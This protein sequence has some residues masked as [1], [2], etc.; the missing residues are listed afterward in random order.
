MEEQNRS[1]PDIKQIFLRI[2]FLGLGISMPAVDW[3]LFGWFH[4]LLPLFTFF[5]LREQGMYSG[6]RI[7][8]VSTVAGFFICLLLSS[9]SL[10]VFAV[11]LI[12]AGYMLAYSASKNEEPFLSGLKATAVLCLGWAICLSGI[13]LPGEQSPYVQLLA[14]LNEGINEVIKHYKESGNGSIRMDV[15]METTMEQ[16]KVGLPL[17]LPSIIASFAMVIVFFTAITGNRIVAARCTIQSWESFRFWQLPDKFIWLT[18]LTGILVFIP[19]NMLKTIGA[20]LLLLLS[21]TYCFQGFSITVFFMN[22]WKVPIFIRSFIYVIVIFQSLGTVL[23]FIAGIADTWINFRKLPH[24]ESN[25]K[26]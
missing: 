4:A 8:L 9:V 10:F 14:S 17:I 22:R 5:I 20:N 26:I 21:L 25:Q 7:I 18:I 23:L 24:T 16:M 11:T 12:P 19:N 13:L 3:I 6:N 1:Q 15:A 2:L